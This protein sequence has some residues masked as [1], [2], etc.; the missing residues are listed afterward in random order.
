MIDMLKEKEDKIS[1]CDYDYFYSLINEKEYKK[2]LELMIE[3]LINNTWLNKKLNW[4]FL[5]SLILISLNDEKHFYELKKHLP[6][7]RSKKDRKTKKAQIKSNIGS[8]LCYLL[9]GS[10]KEEENNFYLYRNLKNNN[11]INKLKIELEN[12]NL[13]YKTLEELKQRYTP[14]EV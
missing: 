11:D 10:N 9:Y 3:D 5:G 14:K 6:R 1:S 2:L 13:K 4:Y 12:S 8:W 7:I